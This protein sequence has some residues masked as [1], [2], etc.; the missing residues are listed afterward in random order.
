MLQVRLPV[1]FLVQYDAE[2]L[3]RGAGVNCGR[4]HGKGAGVV[5]LCPGLGK[6]HRDILFWGKRCPMS[7]GPLRSLLVDPLQRPAVLLQRLSK[8]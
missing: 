2:D 3:C 8:G 6:V 7:F 4:G 1:E 5:V